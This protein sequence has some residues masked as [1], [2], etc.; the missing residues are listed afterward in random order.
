MNGF[1]DKISKSY[2]SATEKR[3]S[4]ANRKI[5]AYAKS[6]CKKTDRLLDLGCGTGLFSIALSEYVKNIIAVD[7]S[8]KMIEIA[9]EKKDAQ[10]ILNLSFEVKT[11]EQMDFQAGSYDI[12]CAF[13]VLLY[14]EGYKSLL[15]RIYGIL[16]QG[17]YFVSV[18][19]CVGENKIMRV[20][21][22]LLQRMR[23]IPYMNQFTTAQLENVI[24]QAGFRIVFSE[25]VYEKTPNYFIV[26]Q[27]I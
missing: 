25:N 27:K 19:D 13:N 1:W 3:F 22:K 5:I 7:S 12:I 14:I 20:I 11:I 8:E 6:Y 17:G 18:T 15:D 16:P 2:D 23:I 21:N 24:I 26:A 9:N 4:D 10:N